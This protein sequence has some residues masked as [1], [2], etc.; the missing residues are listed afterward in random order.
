[1]GVLQTRVIAPIERNL[2]EQADAKGISLYRY[3]QLILTEVGRG[4]VRTV[5]EVPTDS[6]ILLKAN[7]ISKS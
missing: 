6:P 2:Q 4:N 1:M 5:I 7:P 3:I